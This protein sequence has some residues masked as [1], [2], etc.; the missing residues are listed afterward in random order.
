MPRSLLEAG[1]YEVELDVFDDPVPASWGGLLSRS[2][3]ASRRPA[4]R[5]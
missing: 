2:K 3:R 5:P 4:C 1:D